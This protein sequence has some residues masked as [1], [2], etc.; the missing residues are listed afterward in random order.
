MMSTLNWT[1]GTRNLGAGAGDGDRDGAGDGDG[2]GGGGGHRQQNC[3]P[4]ALGL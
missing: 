1:F 3:T 4:M 2:D